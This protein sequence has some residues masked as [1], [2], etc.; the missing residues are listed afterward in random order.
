MHVFASAG[1]PPAVRVNQHGV[2]KAPVALSYVAFKNTCNNAE[3]L[4]VT[5]HSYIDKV[6]DV[7]I[8]APY[9][10]IYE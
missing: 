7:N 8:Y 1:S 5:I 10:Y 4:H 6:L 3:K 2:R 9:I